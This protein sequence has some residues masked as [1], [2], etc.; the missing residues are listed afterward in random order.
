MTPRVVALLVA[1]FAV[2][3]IGFV[4]A[5]TAV[6]RREPVK[7][8]FYREATGINSHISRVKADVVAFDEDYESAMSRKNS[9]EILGDMAE[10]GP[11]LTNGGSRIP[12]SNGWANASI[13]IET[14]I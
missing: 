12:G 1:I 14:R 3:L 13:R 8:S 7:M 2:S 11:T 6:P 9:A 5:Q 10:T 4:V